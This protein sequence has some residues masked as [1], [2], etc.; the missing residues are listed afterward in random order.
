LFNYLEKCIEHAICFIFT[1]NCSL[2]I[3][4]ANEQLVNYARK[5]TQKRKL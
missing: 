4:H 1:H 5:I 3:F 2:N